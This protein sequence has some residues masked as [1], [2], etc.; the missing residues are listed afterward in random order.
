MKMH[1]KTVATRAAPFGSDICTKSFSA[2]T[3]VYDRPNYVFVT[4]CFHC[5]RLVG[6]QEGHPANNKGM[7]GC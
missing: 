2:E 5:R 6:R 1:K 3:C 4:K 7:L